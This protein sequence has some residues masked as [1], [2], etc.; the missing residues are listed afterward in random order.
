M[1]TATAKMGASIKSLPRATNAG[2]MASKDGESL[3]QS[4]DI[5]TLTRGPRR[6]QPAYTIEDRGHETPCW[7]WRGRIDRGG[8]GRAAA[9]ARGYHKAAHR[10]TYERL[11]GPI[12]EKCELDHLCRNRACVN[13]DHLEPVTSAENAR[14]GACTTLTPERVALIKAQPS[15]RRADLAAEFGVSIGTIDNIRAGKRWAEIEA[16][17]SLPLH[18]TR[19]DLTPTNKQED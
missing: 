3:T 2:S 16:D 15:R 11:R 5:P 7:I 19:R 12:P 17:R 4:Q 13:P 14:R 10:V 6:G 8:Y 18:G 9:G 1:T